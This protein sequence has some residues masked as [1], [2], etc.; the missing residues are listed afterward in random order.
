M[1]PLNDPQQDARTWSE[2]L[3]RQAADLST[4]NSQPAAMQ[5]DTPPQTRLATILD[6]F[7]QRAQRR[8][9]VAAK[10]RA[11]EFLTGS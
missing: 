8:E 9:Q 1:N 4:S 5:F 7:K 6:H 10:F 2:Q 11:N 3:G